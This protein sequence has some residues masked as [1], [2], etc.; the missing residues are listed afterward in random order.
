LRRAKVLSVSSAN[1]TTASVHRASARAAHVAYPCLNLLLLS[2]DIDQF[3]LDLSCGGLL[4][5]K[6]KSVQL[7]TAQQAPGA[8]E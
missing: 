5:G 2:S 4:N 3:F 1:A 6:T 7:T 8:L